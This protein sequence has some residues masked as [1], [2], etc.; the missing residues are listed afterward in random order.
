MRAIDPR[1]TG[2]IQ[3]GTLSSSVPDRREPQPRS[4]WPSS[5]GV[6][7]W[8]RSGYPLA[9]SWANR[10]RRP[11]SVW[12]STSW[13]TL[14]VRSRNFQAFSERPA[15]FRC[16]RP[17]RPMSR[18]FSSRSTGFGLCVE[19]LAFDEALRSNAVAAGATLL[20]GVRFQSCARIAD[21]SF[22]WQLT[23]TSETR[24]RQY[25]ARYL[26]DCSGR[27]AVVA[28]T[29]GVQTAHNDD[30]LFAYAQWFSCVR[31]R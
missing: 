20:K 25:R 10:C 13:E 7:C 21:R 15:T 14:K 28:R 5:V 23:L 24:A 19:R 11:L 29:L 27:R 26:V 16:G 9:S 31:R 30:R 22:N 4:R 17:S 12:S 1:T 18:T 3:H 6:C 2:P 8:W